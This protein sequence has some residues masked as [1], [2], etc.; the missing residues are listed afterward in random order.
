MAEDVT[1]ELVDDL[2]NT[3]GSTRYGTDWSLGSKLC[4]VDQAKNVSSGLLPHAA[5]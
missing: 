3:G 5:L 1:H 2:G 4:E